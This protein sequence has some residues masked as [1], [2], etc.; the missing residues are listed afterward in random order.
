MPADGF[1]TVN[2]PDP[3]VELLRPHYGPNKPYRSRDEL[4]KAFVMQGLERMD[5]ASA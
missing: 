3:V 4:V 1:K 5:Q 2:L